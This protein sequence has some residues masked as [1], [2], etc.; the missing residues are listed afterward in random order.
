LAVC[1]KVQEIKPHVLFIQEVVPDSWNM[2]K[3]RLTEYQH[4]CSEDSWLY[5]YFHIISIHKDTLE[6]VGE[7]NVT[8][9]PGTEMGRHLLSCQVKFG[10]ISLHLFSSHLES[11]LEAAPERKR[12]LSEVFAQMAALKEKGDICIFGGDLNLRDNEVKSVGIPN[13]VVDVWE[14]CGSPEDHQYTWDAETNDNYPWNLPTKPRER[15]DRLYLC[16]AEEEKVRP[17]GF[18]LIG[19]DRVASIGRFPSDHYGIYVEFVC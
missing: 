11:T 3:S 19:T 7:E 1:E 14:A 5:P 15:L 2:L 6:V 17:Q 18:T 4:F 12:Q 16:P 13:G 8:D 10:K 9:F